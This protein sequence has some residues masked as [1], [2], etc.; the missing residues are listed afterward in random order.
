MKLSK[1]DYLLS[2]LFCQDMK[3]YNKKAFDRDKS[4]KEKKV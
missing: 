2:K 4:K 3:I 1:T